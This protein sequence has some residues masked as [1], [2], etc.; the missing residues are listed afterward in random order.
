M[1]SALLCWMESDLPAGTTR[2]YRIVAGDPD[3]ESAGMRLVDVP[4]DVLE[5]RDGARLLTAYHYGRDVARPCLYPVLGPGGR[6]L[7]RSLDATPGDEHDFDH[8]HHRSL[9]VA[10]GDVNGA[11]NWSEEPGHGRTV[12]REFRLREEGPVYARFVALARWV[13]A[14]GTPLLDET[15]R[16]TIYRPAPDERVLLDIDLTLHAAYGSIRFGDTKEAALLSVRVAPS[17]Q[18]DRGGQIENSS[19]ALTEAETWGRPAQWCDY[20]GD[21]GDGRIAGIAVLDHPS[22]PRHPTHWHVRGYGL[23]T[24]NPFGLSD[25][26]DDPA[27]DGALDLAPGE[28][29]TWRYRIVIHGGRASDGQVRGA[30]LD[31][32]YPPTAP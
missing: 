6:G 15:R 30:Y 12:H 19:G 21:V 9:W 16:V 1:D 17:M 32:A 3:P 25:F 27:R 2:P 26:Y 23:M 7:T 18:G 29:L 11:D 22:N 24:A 5:V 8:P 28:S 13:T 10:H 31:Y 4:G 14:A 20:S